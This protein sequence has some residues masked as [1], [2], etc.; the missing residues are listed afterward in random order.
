MINKSLI[1]SK[2]RE[3][4]NF[5]TDV[6]LANFLGVST[7]NL[8][9]WHKRNTFDINKIVDKLPELSYAWLLT[10]EG[11]MLKD[12]LRAV[13]STEKNYKLVPLWN[14]DAVGGMNSLNGVLPTEAE[15]I[16]DTIPFTGALEGDICVPVTGNS[17]HPTCPAGSVI[18]I[19]EVV[20][21]QEYFGFGNIF[22]ILLKDGRRVL[23]EVKR[24]DDNPK[25][26]VLCV[27][28]NMDVSAEELP[29]EM[30]FKVW[31]VIKIQSN[32][33]W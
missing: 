5:D 8:S 27:S 30:I 22:Y 25:E 21:W 7:Q 31:K 12:G 2:I 19:R 29:R 17:M 24:C 16:I 20:K 9:A 3:Y 4:K 13:E 23:K 26:Y 33:G 14:F 28:H 11:E 15:Y 32:V 1:L 10:G 18:L 6:A